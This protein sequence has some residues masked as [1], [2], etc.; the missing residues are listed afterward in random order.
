MPEGAAR[1]YGEMLQ[2]RTSPRRRHQSKLPQ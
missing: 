1:D 2:I